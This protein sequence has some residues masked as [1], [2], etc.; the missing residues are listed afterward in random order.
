MKKPKKFKRYAE[1]GALGAGGGD[2]F[3][4]TD[5]EPGRGEKNLEGI[6]N[7]FMGRRSKDEPSAPIE[8]RDTSRKAPEP[9]KAEPV[10]AEPVKAEPVKAEPVKAEPA[11]TS[12][13]KTP[14]VAQQMADREKGGPNEGKNYAQGLASKPDYESY[15]YGPDYIEDKDVGKPREQ[16][17]KFAG[18]SKKAEEYRQSLMPVNK[19]KPAAPK[20]AEKT[21]VTPA[22]PSYVGAG[23]SDDSVETKNKNELE[24][25]KRVGSGA[26]EQTMMG[27]VETVALGA[28][29]LPAMA[30]AG[31]G[32]AR[33]AYDEFTSPS[34]GKGTG[35]FP[36]SKSVEVSNKPAVER[37]KDAKIEGPPKPPRQET[38]VRET[39]AMEKSRKANEVGPPD[40]GARARQVAKDEAKGP[41]APPKPKTPAEQMGL[42]ET[43]AIEKSRKANEVGPPDLGARSRRVAEDAAKDQKQAEGVMAAANQRARQTRAEHKQASDVMAAAKKRADVNRAQKRSDLIP[44][45]DREPGMLQEYISG[46]DAARTRARDLPDDGLSTPRYANKKGGKIPAFKNGGLVSRADGCAI[47]GRTKGRM[48]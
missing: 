37:V 28:S 44:A 35:K 2:P 30:R 4:Y 29:K 6:K 10:K 23:D 12:P 16:S 26:V 22:K 27:P 24:R 5:F 32:A 17:F 41:P 42:R 31:F 46:R 9:V 48:V 13:V 47:R 43:S 36:E 1:G 8:E 11:K 25:L 33:K 45:K 20:A 18:N 40:L 34:G 7:F 3:A 39:S 19:P 14:R 38:S 21:T 15:T